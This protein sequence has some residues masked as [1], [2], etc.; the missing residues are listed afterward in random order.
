MEP[1]KP[2][3]TL[4]ASKVVN[5]ICGC[6][7][8]KADE[9]AAKLNADQSSELVK[10]YESKDQPREF[11]SGVMDALAAE[12]QKAEAAKETQPPAKNVKPDPK[13]STDANV[14]PGA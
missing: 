9:I 3:R 2:N 7:R 8:I 5:A 14:A 12:K 4:T 1:T 13:P 10:R 6:G 11:L